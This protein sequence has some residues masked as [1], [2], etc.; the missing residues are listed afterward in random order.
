MYTAWFQFYENFWKGVGG[1]TT[2]VLER[3]FRYVLY[4]NCDGGYKDV[5]NCSKLIEKKTSEFSA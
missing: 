5:N 4:L 2:K 3:N 1:L